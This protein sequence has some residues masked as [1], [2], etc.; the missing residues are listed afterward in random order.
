[1]TVTRQDGGRVKTQQNL[2][3]ITLFTMFS[4]A[5]FKRM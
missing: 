3:K 1:M 5:R 4:Y 2:P